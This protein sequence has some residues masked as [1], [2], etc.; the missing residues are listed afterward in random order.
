MQLFS[1]DATVF[2]DPENMRKCPQKLLIIGLKLFF[3]Y[4]LG[5]QNDPETKNPYPKSL[6]MQDWL[7]RLGPSPSPKILGFF[8]FGSMYCDSF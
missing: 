8:K 5:C 1:A 6:L 4:W 3:Q 7:F 2:F